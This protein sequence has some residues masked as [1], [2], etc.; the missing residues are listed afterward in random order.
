[1]TKLSALPRDII[2]HNATLP[3]TAVGRIW[4]SAKTYRASERGWRMEDGKIRNP[5]PGTLNSVF[6]VPPLGGVPEEQL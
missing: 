6:G 5:E 4:P 3:D 2:R 1:V